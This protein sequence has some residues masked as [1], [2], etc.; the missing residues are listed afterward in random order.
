MPPG[1]GLVPRPPDGIRPG[2]LGVFMLGRVI[3]GDVAATLVDLANRRLLDVQQPDGAETG[4]LLAPLA[5]PA[6]GRLRR[7]RARLRADAAGRARRR[8][9]RRHHVIACPRMA[10]LL[11][12]TR[13]ELIHDAVRRG[14]LRRLHHDRR[15][16][17]GER[18]AERIRAFQRQLRMY[19]SAQGE[20][21]LTGSLL[22][23]ALHFGMAGNADLLLVRFAR[24][25][26]SRFSGLPGWHP[27]VPSAPNPLDDAVPMD[28]SWTGY[29]RWLQQ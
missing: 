17:E 14:W 3:I 15:T 16:S 24:Q 8:R 19:A 23:Y 21:A 26:V 22:P 13:R 10:D 4:W 11:A 6:P 2:Q 29:E 27:P 9:L 1:D 18:L 5:S 12:D 25:W 7:I 20:R 28:N